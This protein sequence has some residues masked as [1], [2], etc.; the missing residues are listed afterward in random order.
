MKIMLE[1]E[2]VALSAKLTI[3]EEEAAARDPTQRFVMPRVFT[4]DCVMVQNYSR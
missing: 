4:R 1:A 3:G 2:G